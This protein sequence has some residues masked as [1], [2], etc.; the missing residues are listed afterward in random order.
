[1]LRVGVNAAHAV[2]KAFVDLQL[3]LLEQLRGQQRR[4]GDLHDLVVVAVHDQRWR[5]GRLW[6]L[7]K[8]VAENALIRSS[9]ALAPP[10]IPWRH[11]F[12]MIPPDAS[13]PVWRVLRQ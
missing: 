3:G 10:S 9:C 6:V 7:V 8:S 4:V 2:R 12:W 1:M 5:V 13:T 11:Q